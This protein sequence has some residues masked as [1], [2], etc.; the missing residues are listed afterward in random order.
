V[1]QPINLWSAAEFTEL[2]PDR[3]NKFV[4]P[5]PITRICGFGNTEDGDRGSVPGLG[6]GS[7]HIGIDRSTSLIAPGS[8][9]KPFPLSAFL[10]KVADYPLTHDSRTLVGAYQFARVR[11]AD[12]SLTS[13]S[14]VQLLV[15]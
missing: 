14:V 12:S 10:R 3:Q 2:L 13:D 7:R 1:A 4:V 8:R 5:Q 11:C 15:S 6:T 9:E